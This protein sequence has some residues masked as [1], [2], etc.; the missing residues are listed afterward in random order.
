V[1]FAG[2]ALRYLLFVT[3]LLVGYGLVA[4]FGRVNPRLLSQ[5][6]SFANLGVVGWLVVRGVAEGG[7]TITRSVAYGAG[8]MFVVLVPL[9]ASVLLFAERRDEVAARD[10]PSE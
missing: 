5:L 4:R 3:P 8:A 7:L 9:F 2:F 10:V 6:W 1:S